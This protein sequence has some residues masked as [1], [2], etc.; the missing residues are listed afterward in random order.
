MEG[1]DAERRQLTVMFCDIV[2][3]TALAARLDPEDLRD[4][5][6][7]Y[8]DAVAAAVQ[9]FHGHV[10]QYLG[11]GLLVYFGW[12]RAHDDDAPRA[13][14]A[15]LAVLDAVHAL[16]G[17]MASAGGPRIDVR[18]G[19]HT[20]AVVVGDVGAGTRL[21]RLALGDT[22]NVAARLQEA[23]APGTILI[24]GVTAGLLEE[25]FFLEDQ[26][27]QALKGIGDGVRAYRVLGETGIRSRFDLAAQ[28]RLLPLV[29]RDAELARLTE[30]WECARAGAG[31][32][33]LVSGEAGIGKSRLLQ[34][35]KAHVSVTGGR[36]GSMRCSPYFTS[37]P[38]YPVTELWHQAMT[39]AGATAPAERFAW[40]ERQLASHGFDVAVAVPLFADLLGIAVPEGRYPP[41]ALDADARRERAIDGVIAITLNLAQR[42]PYLL[43]FE[44][45]HWVDPTTA[46]V[47][48]R[49][50]DRA[51]DHA[52][53]AV[54][55][56]RPRIE[57]DCVQ[58]HVV[59]LEL[60]RLGDDAVDAM[61]AQ[62]TRDRALPPEVARAIRERA[63]GVPAFVEELCRYVLEEADRGAPATPDAAQIP[64][65]LRD[66]LMARL[67]RTGDAKQLALL[68]ATIGRWF[69]HA[70]IEAVAGLPAARLNDGLRQ[71]VE[72][73]VLAR[74]G[75]PPDATYSFRHALMQEIAY[76]AL[77]RRV[78]R[79]YHAAI[80]AAIETSFSDLGDRHPELLAHHH[81]RAGN[82]ERAVELLHRAAASAAARSAHAEARA[83]AAA[84]DAL[85]RGGQ[86]AAS[87]RTGAADDDGTTGVR[88]P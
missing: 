45:L 76:D 5:V 57:H 37:T 50:A 64:A 82:V 74:D 48:R 35:L 7:A 20:G 23:A 70:L 46:E 58:G 66:S 79:R 84:A 39:F 80:A 40:L 77:L 33:V 87:Q 36:W 65:S 67:D 54:Y 85:L 43:I 62:L 3:S 73:R 15:A 53:L 55:T 11:D 41:L 2:E 88:Q 13:V 78:R 68:G 69:S 38:L 47:L 60:G 31:R 17:R 18:I 51:A 61:L 72:A 86:R 16:D 1:Y 34:A 42:R 81:A 12:P 49:L 22:P 56:S 6:R 32:V 30:L 29:G 71:L 52:I 19:V 10:A 4:V 9:R 75:E 14:H 59:G 26:G 44:D 28:A 24:S 25:R 8:Q 21:E 83:H 27:P 63:D